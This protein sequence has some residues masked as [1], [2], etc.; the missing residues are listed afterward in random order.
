MR[1]GIHAGALMIMGAPLNELVDHAVDAEAD[2]FATYWLPQSGATDALTVIALCGA[3]TSSIDTGGPG[4]IAAS[5]P[6]ACSEPIA[7]ACCIS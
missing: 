6:A 7:A 4:R 2:G 1:I 5:D 3:A